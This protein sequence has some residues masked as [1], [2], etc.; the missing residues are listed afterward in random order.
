[1]EINPANKKVFDKIF[2]DNAWGG[3]DSK[4][5]PGSNIIQTEVLRNA[6]PDFF[7]KHQVKSI[8]DIPCGDFYW[9][10][11]IKGNLSKVIDRY[12]GGDIVGEIIASNNLKY[13]DTKF[14]F[15]C[16]DITTSAL[17]KV[18]LIFCRDCLVHLSYPNIYHALRNIKKSGSS[19][20]LTTSFT[21]TNRK[22][23]NIG[24]G[25]WRPLNFQ[26]FPFYFPVPEDIINEKCTEG[27]GIYQ[28][29]SL[30]LWNVRKLNLS[31]LFAFL[32][33][34]KI[35]NRIKRIG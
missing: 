13:Q 19:F 20:L 30:L 31:F 5:G 11:E 2:L 16:L 4:S 7:L 22:N 32:V 35:K 18:D 3:H 25:G 27:N 34:H 29:K 23:K 24:T 28:D 26:K 1:M 6:L 15:Q 14:S 21:D 10:K 8:L 9:M 12:T 33:F 17:P